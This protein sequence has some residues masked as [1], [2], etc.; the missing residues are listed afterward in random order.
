MK[1][2]RIVLI[3]VLISTLAF[4]PASA[5]A[6]P[7]RT[8]ANGGHTDSKT[9]EYHYHTGNEAT[10]VSET[11]SAINRPTVEIT[12]VFYCLIA[13]GGSGAV[14]VFSVKSIKKKRPARLSNKKGA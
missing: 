5:A 8:D 12:M 14:V 7:G 4:I 3:F 9:G 11:A 10:D 13:F 6:H 2:A 1:R